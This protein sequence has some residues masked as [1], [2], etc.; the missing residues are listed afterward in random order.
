MKVTTTF[1]VAL[2]LALVWTKFLSAQGCLTQNSATL[3]L[4]VT[5]TGDS[6]DGACDGDCSLREAILV[7][8]ANPGIDTIILPAG[9][10]TLTL[11]GAGEDGAS[12]G[13]LDILDSVVISGNGV[14]SPTIDGGGLDRV[15]HIVTSS[16]VVS[17]SNL[18]IRNGRAPDSD[19]GGGGI[20]SQGILSLENV[21]LE[22]N[23]AARG[24]GLRNSQ[25]SVHLARSTVISNTAESEGGGIFSDG[26]LLVRDSWIASNQVPEG[27]G[28]GIGSSEKALLERVTLDVIRAMQCCGL[29]CDV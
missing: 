11:V 20:L 29:Y 22:N 5:K 10:Y 14:T 15:F 9:V 8:N 17:L 28:G 2:F 13:D 18:I 7:A 1:L 27:H 25:G 12:T 3:T 21:R 24:G 4:T 16:A 19:M 6:A 23:W 26:S